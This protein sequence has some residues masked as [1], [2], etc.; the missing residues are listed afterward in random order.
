M[1]AMQIRHCYFGDASAIWS[2]SAV[3]LWRGVAEGQEPV[4]DKKLEIVVR[5][6][7]VD[8]YGTTYVVAVPM[9]REGTNAHPLNLSWSMWP[10]DDGR[11]FADLELSCYI[12]KD[13]GPHGCEAGY[14]D[15]GSIDA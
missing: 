8:R 10:S 7:T 14:R 9:D 13:Y 2:V 11:E 1:S 15:A 6:M 5:L 3:P 4:T 12:S